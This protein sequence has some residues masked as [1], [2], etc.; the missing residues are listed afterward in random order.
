ME[1]AKEDKRPVLIDFWSEWCLPCKQMDSELYTDLKVIEASRR[2]VLIRVD[3]DSD[4]D[5]PSR[6]TV[7]SLPM[8]L[9]MDPRETVLLSVK[10]N[11]KPGELLEMMK[12]IPQSFEPI[13]ESF[14]T[15]EEDS[16]DV[17][18]L[19]KISA[20]YREAGFASQANEFSARAEKAGHDAKEPN[21]RAEDQRDLSPPAAR[22]GIVLETIPS[23]LSQSILLPG[24]GTYTPPTPIVD[25]STGELLKKYPEEL[26]G[27][28]FDPNQDEL[29][30]LLEK[31]GKNVSAFFGNLPNT[32]SK[33]RIRQERLRADGRISSH[34]EQDVEYL[35][36]LQK[37]GTVMKWREERT[38]NKGKLVRLKRLPVESFLTS[39]FAL[40]C[41]LFFPD[42]QRASRFRYL[43]RQSSEP[44]AHLIS[45]A[46]RP[47]IGLIAGEFQ[48]QGV[49]VTIWSQGLVWV[50][51]KT[52]QITRMRIDLLEPKPE[53]GLTRQTTKIS[54]GEYQFSA[55]GISLWLPREVA[56]T[57]EY[58]AK[59]YRNTHRYSDYRLFTVESYEK[60]EP[61]SRPKV[62]K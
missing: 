1:L 50:D 42:Y 25:L 46:Q 44:Y 52:Y 12:P 41:V 29:G 28:E 16:T 11:T 22:P 5:T 8:K 20:F 14:T 58:G 9:F 35:L 39:G 13:S 19:L 38:D 51:P 55:Q 43:G 34:V 60:H 3:V 62:P 33:E 21:A 2:F 36:F 27:V 15:L 37:G 24:M 57:I 31:I 32:L 45:F 54:Y 56:V 23:R 59:V 18:A 61:I 40:Y 17:D 53:A 10:G 49:S 47:E 4:H 26:L 7:K 30:F 6:F 48:M